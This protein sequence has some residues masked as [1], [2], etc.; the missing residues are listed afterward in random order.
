VYYDLVIL[1]RR[2]GGPIGASTS[3]REGMRVRD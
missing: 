3:K 1:E 2:H